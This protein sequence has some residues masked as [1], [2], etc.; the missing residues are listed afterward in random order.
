MIL[1]WHILDHLAPSEHDLNTTVYLSIVWPEC[2]HPF[3]HVSTGSSMISHSWH[4]LH[5]T[6]SQSNRALLGFGEIQSWKISMWCYG[7]KSIRIVSSAVLSLFYVELREFW[8]QKG[9]QPG[10]SKVSIKYPYTNT[11]TS[12]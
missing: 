3:M 12:K 2:S 7:T 4:G 10:T 11:K 6:R 9:L 8:K 5:S 1:S